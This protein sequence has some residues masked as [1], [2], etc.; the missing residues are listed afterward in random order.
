MV[1]ADN[2]LQKMD[3]ILD[4]ENPDICMNNIILD[5]FEFYEFRETED[6]EFSNSFD[7]LWDD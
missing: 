1:P 3:L 5:D 7:S 6:E 4:F 2:R